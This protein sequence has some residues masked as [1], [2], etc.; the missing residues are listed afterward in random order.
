MAETNL[1]K[2]NRAE[3]IAL[4]EDLRAELKKI[5]PEKTAPEETSTSD[6]D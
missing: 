3:L 2:L 4:L 5:S 6:V 1:N